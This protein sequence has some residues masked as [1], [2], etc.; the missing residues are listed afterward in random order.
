MID[1]LT[2]TVGRM[3]APPAGAPAKARFLGVD[4]TRGI[5]LLSMLAANNFAVLNDNGTPTF[6]VMTVT[7]RSA[8]L[9]VMVAGI[10]LA[11]I[12]GGR[13]PVQGRARRAAAVGIAVR[14]L[15][16]AA[17][18]LG[19]GYFAAADFGVILGYYG[20]FFLLAIPL[21]WLRPRTL[22]SIAGVLVVVGPLLLLGAFSLGLGPAFDT[23]PTLGAPFTHPIGFVLLLL[24]TGD[25]PAAVYMIYICA[26]LAIGR[27]DLSSTRVA[28]WLL[29]GGVVMAVT[30]WVTSSVILF[31]LGG[32]QHLH[33]A[34]DPGTPPAQVTNQIVWDPNKVASWWWLALRGHHTG[35]PFDAL[36]TLGVAMAVLGGV[37]LVI[38]LRAARR[39]LWPVGVAGT[40]TLT[41]YSA[42]VLFLNSGLLS[43]NDYVAYAEQV[44]VALAFAMVWYRFMGQGPLER[45]VAMASGRA[46]RAVMPRPVQAHIEPGRGAEPSELKDDH[47]AE[48]ATTLTAASSPARTADRPGERSHELASTT[49]TATT[50]PGVEIT[51]APAVVP[52]P[53]GGRAAPSVG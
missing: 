51:M 35:T 22:A 1:G 13:H 31:H 38:K 47:T 14:A 27:L 42:Q 4:V 6:A 23:S 2:K 19:L 3:L 20:L 9:F 12:T 39:L 53:P 37:L 46:R 33:A 26:G 49:P 40:M 52:Q 36:H 43:D 11:F 18:G 7:G 48:T 50:T 29:G 21:L 30:A 5:A 15:L 44:A 28:A 41:I 34:V 8:T 25:F 17:I 45:I 10:S 32:L 24:V 16:I